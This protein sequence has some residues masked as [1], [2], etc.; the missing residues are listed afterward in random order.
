MIIPI[1]DL[2]RSL[3]NHPFTWIS[4]FRYVGTLIYRGCLFI[5]RL[6]RTHLT[7]R[8]PRWNFFFA[9]YTTFGPFCRA[10]DLPAAL[11]RGARCWLCHFPFAVMP[12][13][14]PFSSRY[15]AIV[16]ECVL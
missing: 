9:C 11:S 7:H 13:T 10:D 2:L 3:F 8:L 6:P 16:V 12:G 15:A 5:V 14:L 4:G 1:D